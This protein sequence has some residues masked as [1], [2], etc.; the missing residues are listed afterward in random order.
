MTAAQW[1]WLAGV[2]GLGLSVGSFLNVVI[3]RV[4]FGDSLAWPGSRCPN[5]FRPIDWNQNIPVLSWIVL[6]GRCNWC[7]I[8]IAVRYPIVEVLTMVVFVAVFWV[9]PHPLATVAWWYF[10]ASLIALAFIDFDHLI[11]PDVLT[12]PL[13]P[14]GIV[15]VSLFEGRMLPQTAIDVISGPA[16]LLSIR[17]IYFWLR[18][19][20]GIG[21]GDVKLSAGVGAFLGWPGVVW[22]MIVGSLIGSVVG[23]GQIA[24]GRGTMKSALPFGPFL[25]VAAL[26]WMFLKLTGF[27]G[28][29]EPFLALPRI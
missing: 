21:L 19:V 8:P 23:L 17:L 11:L 24:L 1:V 15:F 10:S 12:L 6:G 2:A 25:V 20:E 3:G 22:T 4:P 14:V 29:I 26:I 5:C 28:A 27:A 13:I 18:G 9:T 7:R 16:I